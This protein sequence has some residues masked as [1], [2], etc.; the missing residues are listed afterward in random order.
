MGALGDHCSR[1]YPVYLSSPPR[2]LERTPVVNSM[3]AHTAKPI[4]RL[5]PDGTCKVR[6]A[7]YYLLLCIKLGDDTDFV[8]VFL[9]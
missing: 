4:P 6:G 7:N 2:N 1:C 9:A 3:V 8:S 5:S